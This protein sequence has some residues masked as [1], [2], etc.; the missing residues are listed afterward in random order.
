MT[1]RYDV[2]NGKGRAAKR[3][4]GAAAPSLFLF[5]FNTLLLLEV[6]MANRSLDAK[7]KRAVS[8][9]QEAGR[10]EGFK[11]AYH[12]NKPLLREIAANAQHMVL[13]ARREIIT[14]SEPKTVLYNPRIHRAQKPL[15][16]RCAVA[17]DG[18][19]VKRADYFS[20]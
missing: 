7:H 5:A 16:L 6:T 10:I 2:F 3:R 19:L 20:R 9:R 14:W 11:P 4:H 13:P 12:T 15:V 17:C 8:Q 18:E 1:K